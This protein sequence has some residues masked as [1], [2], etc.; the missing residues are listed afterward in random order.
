MSPAEV[1]KLSLFFSVSY[2]LAFRRDGGGGGYCSLSSPLDSNQASVSPF[3]Q[4]VRSIAVFCCVTAF[5]KSKGCWKCFPPRSAL[6]RERQKVT[7]ES[8]PYPALYPEIHQCYLIFIP[9]RTSWR[10]STLRNVCTYWN[11]ELGFEPRST[12]LQFEA[13]SIVIKTLHTFA[14]DNTE[15]RFFP[16][17]VNAESELKSHCMNLNYIEMLFF[18]Y[19][20]GRNEHVCCITNFSWGILI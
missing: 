15:S 11:G 10:S 12:E 13:I 6:K 2:S 3:V 16:P 1:W 7:E 5:C 19:Q 4:R 9:I 18:A 14:R 8:C 20:Y 17:E